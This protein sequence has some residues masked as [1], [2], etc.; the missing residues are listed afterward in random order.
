MRKLRPRAAESLSPSSP[1]V[2]P[3]A[4][5]L[6]FS[7]V[8]FTSWPSPRRGPVPLEGGLGAMNMN[9]LAQVQKADPW[10]LPGAGGSSGVPASQGAGPY[11][12]RSWWSGLGSCMAFRGACMEPLPRSRVGTQRHL[13]VSVLERKGVC[14]RGRP[15]ADE[16]ST[17]RER[18]RSVSQTQGTT[19]AFTPGPASARRGP[20]HQAP[21]PAD[22]TSPAS[23]SRTLPG[24]PRHFPFP[25]GESDGSPL[26]TVHGSSLCPGRSSSRPLPDSRRTPFRVPAPCFVSLRTPGHARHARG[27]CRLCRGLPAPLGQL[28]KDREFFFSRCCA[29]LYPRCLERI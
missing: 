21:V 26:S 15:K 11:R 27:R 4:D 25:L 29:L 16:G 14:V 8:G 13:L 19:L 10:Q 5:D 12:V 17:H 3:R 20:H 6:G 1:R 28:R 22:V 9:T 2:P 24:H 18:P 23:P 7:W